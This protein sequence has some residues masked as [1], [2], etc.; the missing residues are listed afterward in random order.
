MKVLNRRFTPRERALLFVLALILVALVYFVAVDNPVRT[1]LQTARIEQ[2]SL[3]I[4]VL[5][6]E[7]RVMEI[8]QMQ[9]ELDEMEQRGE[10]VSR[11]LSY[12]GENREIDFLHTTLADTLDYYI[13]FNQVTR[14]GDLIRREFSLQYRAASYDAAVAVMR[15]LEESRIRCLVGDVSM[16]PASD[17][18][19][20]SGGGQ[21]MV[22]CSATFYETMEGSKPDRELPPDT[23]QGDQGTVAQ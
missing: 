6:V 23:A 2:D 5:A 7:N 15:K 3:E 17:V 4:Q 11:M 10:V 22:N 18:R 21:V 9:R 1:G 13:G 12:N 16:N 14:E 20:I 8:F 19:T